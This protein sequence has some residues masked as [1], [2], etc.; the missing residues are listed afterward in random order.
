MKLEN[1]K[2]SISQTKNPMFFQ[3]SFHLG[4]DKAK[5][6]KLSHGGRAFCVVAKDELKALMGAGFKPFSLAG[7]EAELREEDNIDPTKPSL[8]KFD[9]LSA[10]FR[11]GMGDWT[12]LL[13][14]PALSTKKETAESTPGF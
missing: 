11:G 8:L 13:N 4:E 3:L 5:E 12:E 6:A 14:A 2:L 1:I 9:L 7:V 10:Q